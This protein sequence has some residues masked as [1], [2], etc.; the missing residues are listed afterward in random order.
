MR[1]FQAVKKNSI[2][3]CWTLG[4]IV[5]P[6]S[7]STEDLNLTPW[8][9]CKCRNRLDFDTVNGTRRH[10]HFQ[11]SHFSPRWAW[12]KCSCK[13]SCSGFPSEG[14]HLY[15]QNMLHTGAS[16]HTTCA[17]WSS[18]LKSLLKGPGKYVWAFLVTSMVKSL[19]CNGTGFDP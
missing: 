6:A 11:I 15:R 4:N 9:C 2:F 13:S 8:G 1:S 17:P 18:G 5:P 10:L 12:S 14:S 19:P 3:L 7:G 16:K